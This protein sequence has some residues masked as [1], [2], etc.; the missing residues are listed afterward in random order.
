MPEDEV[1][2]RQFAVIAA[3]A[4]PMAAG[5]FVGLSTNNGDEVKATRLA[6]A[7][8]QKAANLEKAAEQARAREA[9]EAAKREKATLL[10]QATAEKKAAEQAE[11]EAAAREK[12]EKL[13]SLI[14]KANEVEA[15]AQPP[16]PATNAK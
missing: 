2:R 7:E 9:K 15:S 1:S 12:K 10:A 4:V 14:V 16:T 3:A 11:R 6:K 5:Y 8:A 13:A